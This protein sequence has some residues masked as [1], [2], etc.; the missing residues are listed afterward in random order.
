VSVSSNETQEDGDDNLCPK[1]RTKE[2][3]AATSQVLVPRMIIR[4]HSY[5][6]TDYLFNYIT[7]SLNHLAKTVLFSLAIQPSERLG[8]NVESVD[9]SWFSTLG[10]RFER[11]VFRLK[12]PIIADLRYA[13]LR[14]YWLNLH[15]TAKT[16]PKMQDEAIRVGKLL[17]TN[18]NSTGWTVRDYLAPM[19]DKKDNFIPNAVEWHVEILQRPTQQHG[20]MQNMGSRYC[21]MQH[22]GTGVLQRQTDDIFFRPLQMDSKDRVASWIRDS[23]K[24]VISL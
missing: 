6:I 2:W 17:L 5:S 11:V 8:R 23:R 16:Y 18:N 19:R 1:R 3:K 12:C 7:Q 21:C 14:T 20:H 22:S 15:D 10:R 13:H 24:S 9:L 4:Q